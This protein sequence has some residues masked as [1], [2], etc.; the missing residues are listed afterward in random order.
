MDS[1]SG[2]TVAL[3]RKS[4]LKRSPTPTSADALATTHTEVLYL[5]VPIEQHE[6]RG[7]EAEKMQSNAVAVQLVMLS[8][9]LS[10][11]ATAISYGRPLSVDSSVLVYEALAV[12]EFCGIV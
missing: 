11:C 9:R 8:K 7:L 1:M 6:A 10:E 3:A 2:I 5:R 12:A 4:E